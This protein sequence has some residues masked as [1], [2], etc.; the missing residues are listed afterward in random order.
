MIT[1][2]SKNASSIEE[3]S[4]DWDIT[5]CH[6]C[7]FTT[8]HKYYLKEHT[9]HHLISFALQCPKCSY[10]VDSPTPLTRHIKGHH[11]VDLE[12]DSTTDD[13]EVITLI[14]SHSVVCYMFFILLILH[15][16]RWIRSRIA[17]K[18][19]RLL[20]RNSSASTKPTTGGIMMGI[21]S[22]IRINRF[23]NAQSV[24]ILWAISFLS[25]VTWCKARPDFSCHLL[26]TNFTEDIFLYYTGLSWKHY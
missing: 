12:P 15:R 4:M 6:H 10:S 9:Q 20:K 1:K 13:K 19:C 24:V 16:F 21:A 26:K 18:F 2:P 11:R 14:F 7:D 3:K 17:F 8:R 22:F 5:S 23:I 25:L